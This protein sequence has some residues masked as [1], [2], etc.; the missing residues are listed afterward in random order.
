MVI[1]YRLSR[2]ILLFVIDLSVIAIR[3]SVIVPTTGYRLE[4]ILVR[5]TE[6][7]CNIESRENI[8]CKISKKNKVMQTWKLYINDGNI[9][10][11]AC[12]TD[13]PG[14]GAEIV[15]RDSASAIRRRA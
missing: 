13:G 5:G 10:H 1:I 8:R 6:E 9:C 3:F 12:A 2:A 11:V 14:R 15:R 7:W 4:H